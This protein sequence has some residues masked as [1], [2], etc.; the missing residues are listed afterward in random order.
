MILA[1]KSVRARLCVSRLKV[2]QQTGESNGIVVL[3][4]APA[5][6]RAPGLPNLGAL[7]R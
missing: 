1:R 4:A 7:Q 5:L 3:A 6:D 2:L